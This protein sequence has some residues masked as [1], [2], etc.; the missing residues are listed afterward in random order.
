MFYKRML[1]QPSGKSLKPDS[2][3]KNPHLS[4]AQ[5]RHIRVKGWTKN[6]DHFIKDM[7]IIPFCE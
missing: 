5:K 2:F 6:V 7:I 3:E 4:E 1:T